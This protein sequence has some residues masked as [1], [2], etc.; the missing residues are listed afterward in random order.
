[1]LERGSATMGVWLGKQCLNQTDDLNIN[2]IV[3]LVVAAPGSNIPGE[4]RSS[5]G[6]LDVDTLDGSTIDISSEDSLTDYRK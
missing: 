1:M 5:K 6:T 3:Q 4:M 2:G